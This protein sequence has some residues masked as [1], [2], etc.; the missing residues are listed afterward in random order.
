MLLN[1]YRTTLLIALSIINLNCSDN[2]AEAVNLEDGSAT[3]PNSGNNNNTDNNDIPDISIPV[4]SRIFET[5]NFI[6]FDDAT[7]EGLTSEIWDPSQLMSIAGVPEEGRGIIF[8]VVKV[9]AG[10]GNAYFNILNG[11]ADLANWF[12]EGYFVFDMRINSKDDGAQLLMKLDSGYPDVSDLTVDLPPAGVWRTIRLPVAALH[13]NGNSF[14]PERQANINALISLL[15]IEPLGAM[16]ISFDNIRLTTEPPPPPPPIFAEAPLYTVFDD[17]F[18]PG[19]APVI[20]SPSQKLSLALLP[21]EGL[22]LVLNLANGIQTP[23]RFSLLITDGPVSLANW[24]SG[25]SFVFKMRVNSRADDSGLI[26]KLDSGSPDVSGFRVNLPPIGLWREVRIP[27]ATLEA[28]GNSLESGRADI[29][30]ITNLLVLE[31]SG[32]IDLSFESIR[33]T[34]EPPPPPP[35][36]FAQTPLFTIFDDTFGEGLIPVFFSPNDALSLAGNPEEGRGLVLNLANSDE[37]AGNIAL[38]VTAGP[39]NLENWLAEGSFV[40]ELRVNSAEANTDLL[41]KLD[42]GYPNVS[43]ATVDLPPIGVWTEVRIPI[44]TIYQNGNSLEPGQAD[45][46]SITNLIVFDLR[47]RMDLSFDNIRLTTN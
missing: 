17:D 1:Y 41:V 46:T 36:V 7:A 5:P 26:V 3:G 13:A 47:G 35:E 21:E 39:A 34:T 37:E 40:F 44:S 16:N 14:E 20:F 12:N 31:M 27:I 22:G 45:I 38:Q 28:N 2:N 9:A 11:P 23:S 25:G 18:G 32:Q 30:S 29:E 15:V 10:N 33:L 4:G 42:S 19:L 43:D 6:I 24:L 8:N